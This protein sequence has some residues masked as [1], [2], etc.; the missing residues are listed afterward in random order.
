M[1]EAKLGGAKAAILLISNRYLGSKFC[2]YEAKMLTKELPGKVLPLLVSATDLAAHPFLAQLQMIPWAS[3]RE[4]KPL[5]QLNPPE[6][7]AVYTEVGVWLRRLLGQPV[8]GSGSMFDPVNTVQGRKER[9]A[10]LATRYAED[11]NGAPQ[12]FATEYMRSYSHEQVDTAKKYLEEFEAALKEAH[13]KVAD[14]IHQE[15][16]ELLREGPPIGPV[17]LEGFATVRDGATLYSH[18]A[19]PRLL[20]GIRKMEKSHKEAIANFEAMER[21]MP[22]CALFKYALGQCYRKDKRLANARAK[23]HEALNWARHYPDDY[24][25]CG[26]RCP[27]SELRLAIHR[28]LGAVYRELE[29]W[30]TAEKYFRDAVELA[31]DES[32]SDNVRSD[33]FYSF[34][35]LLYKASFNF[36]DRRADYLDGALEQFKEANRLCWHR[37]A[38]LWRIAIVKHLRDE[39][40]GY[41][42]LIAWHSA[43][44][45]QNIESPLTAAFCGFA[46]LMMDLESA[47]G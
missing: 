47:R 22:T 42:F 8:P 24:C 38:P 12:Q 14:P 43:R 31:R 5:D 29:D 36:G 37:S 23:L 32:L 25:G 28:G 1:I 21:A 19:Y 10:L 9:A 40:T 18:P 39:A 46:L 3:R 16:L 41:D 7:R 2:L 26:P 44:N 17:H 15:I 35:Y 6:R 30:E 4:L 34:G 20:L 27:I 45:E 11:P 33:F 13:S